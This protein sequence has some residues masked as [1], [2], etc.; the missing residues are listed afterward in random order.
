MLPNGADP[1]R[2]CAVK[3]AVYGMNSCNVSPELE[4]DLATQKRDTA[5]AAVSR[6]AL[7]Y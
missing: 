4:F 2:T 1:A 3:R 7:S 6:A 5:A